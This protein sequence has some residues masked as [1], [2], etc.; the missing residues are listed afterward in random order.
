[1]TTPETGERLYLFDRMPLGP[2][3]NSRRRAELRSNCFQ[4]WL[5]TCSKEFA[6]DDGRTAEGTQANKTLER[7]SCITL[8][9]KTPPTRGKRHNRQKMFVWP[10]STTSLNQNF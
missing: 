3:P 2:T 9:L 10:R 7:T 6:P 4:K 1:M 5:S 8:T